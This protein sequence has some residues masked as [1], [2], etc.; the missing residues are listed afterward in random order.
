MFAAGN[1][2]KMRFGV[3]GSIFN[4]NIIRRI[5]QKFRRIM[6]LHFG[7]VTFRIQIGKTRKHVIFMF[8]GL[9][10]RVHDSQNQYYLSLEIP[11]YSKKIMKNPNTFYKIC[12]LEISKFRKSNIL[13]LLEIV[14][15]GG[16]EDPSNMFSKIL[17]MGS[18]SPRNMKWIFGT[19]GSTSITNT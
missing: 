3:W 6:L 2:E 17:N 8:F 4:V 10:G 14:V 5:A 7:L 15:V 1:P 9:G 19:V 11:E 16:P 13:I 18:I 12:L